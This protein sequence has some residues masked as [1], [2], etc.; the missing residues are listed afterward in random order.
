MSVSCCDGDEG[1]DSSLTA[2]PEIEDARQTS[3]KAIKWRIRPMRHAD[4]EKCLEIW[5]QVDLTE[6]HVTV[7]SALKTDP[8]GF[9]VAEL[10]TGRGKYLLDGVFGTIKWNSE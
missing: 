7:A 3:T 1:R 4:I 5:L 9:Y 6:A 10:E 2:R 8:D